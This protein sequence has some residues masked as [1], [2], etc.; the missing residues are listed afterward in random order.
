METTFGEQAVLL[1]HWFYN[2]KWY[3]LAVEGGLGGSWGGEVKAKT[4]DEELNRDR[5]AHDKP[6][7]K[8]AGAE[9]EK[10]TEREPQ[11]LSAH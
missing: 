11:R 3:I 6:K 10:E 1:N 4:G 8:R 5:G 7:T 9:E 2:M